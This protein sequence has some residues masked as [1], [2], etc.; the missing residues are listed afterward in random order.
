MNIGHSNVKSHFASVD[1]TR[2]PLAEHDWTQRHA[3]AAWSTS[4]V[5]PE[6]GH[7]D[8]SA[9]GIGLRAHKASKKGIN[10]D[11][12]NS[13][14]TM[15]GEHAE[16]FKVAMKKEI[17]ALEKHETW[18]G[19][20]K[21]VTPENGEVIPLTWVFRIERKPNGK[22]DKFKARLVVRG[23][24]QHDERETCAP[25]VKWETIRTVPAFALQVKLSVQ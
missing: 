3:L 8:T 5:D 16:E 2:E 19:V 17:T 22:F 18:I 10:P 12:P 9:P 20:L 24:L 6:E 11:P 15:E 7:I 4:A 25:V 14:E 13:R 23:D 21:S 1:R